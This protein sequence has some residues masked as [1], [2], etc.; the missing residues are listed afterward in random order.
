MI[1][2][3][4]ATSIDGSV[5]IIYDICTFSAFVIAGLVV[6]SGLVDFILF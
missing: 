6:K 5:A 1:F 4:H 2:E 3:E